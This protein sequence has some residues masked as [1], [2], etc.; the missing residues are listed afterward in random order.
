[1]ATMNYS[2]KSPRTNTYVAKEMLARVARLEVSGKFAKNADLPQ[3]A[4]EK[5]TFRRLKPFNPTAYET[6][7]ITNTLVTTPGGANLLLSEGTTPTAYAIDYTDVEVTLLNYGVL[8]EFSSK[9]QLLHEDD[10][11]GDMVDLTGDTLGEALEVVR[12]GAMNA[13]TANVRLANAVGAVG[14]IDKPIQAKDLRH[15]ARVLMARRATKITEVLAPSVNVKTEPVEAAFIVLCHSDTEADIRS[16]AGFVHISEYGQRKVIS[17]YELGSWES[18]RFL[19]FP[20]MPVTTD[21]GALTGTTGLVSSGTKV[22]VYDS[23]V[24]AKEAFGQVALRGRTAI[25]PTLLPATQMNHANPM[26]LKGY[27]GANVWYAAK[28]LNENLM[29]KIRHGVTAV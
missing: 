18:F 24:M 16:L 25:K 12:I 13:V 9:A 3:N 22:D 10:I 4:T 19:C 26:G 23:I 28:A 2:T 29:V 5:I 21:L 6:P 1:M 27:V 20:I 15:A 11:P 17:E 8:F 14:S 7:N